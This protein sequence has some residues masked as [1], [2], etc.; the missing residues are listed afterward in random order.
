MHHAPGSEQPNPKPLLINAALTGMVGMPDRIPAIPISAERIARDAWV[1][2]QLGASILHLH[3]RDQDGGPDWH[4]ETYEE[5][6]LA[7]RERCPEAIL[8]V[9][10]SGRTFPELERRAAALAL[11]GDAKPDM[12]SLTLGSLDF[13]TG[14]SVNPPEMVRDLA[15]IMAEA[16]IKPELEVFDSG[17]AN[18][19]TAMLE[20]G[21][22]QAPLYAN[23]ILGAPHTGPATLREL[24]HLTGSLPAGTIWA[25]AGLAA[26]QLEIN[27]ISVFGGG[28][29]RTGLEDNALLHPGVD[30]TNS[31]LVARVAKLAQQAGRPVAGAALARR[32]LGL[33]PSPRRQGHTIRIADLHRDRAAMLRVLEPSNMHHVPSP[34]MDGFEV[35]EW[36]VAESE[37]MIV[38][39]AGFRMLETPAG[40]VGKTTLLAVEPS[41]RSTGIGRA[42]QELRMELMQDAGANRVITN[43]DRPETIAWYERHF[44][45]R[46][47]GSVTKL[48]EFGLPGVDEWTTLEATLPP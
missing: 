22:L 42:L 3:A 36:F 34:E 11:A 23:V 38:G 47:V 17:M 8:C 9:S 21:E 18:V 41:I 6:L 4:P 31:A 7:V 48:H 44:G 46:R 27:S 35:G 1:C 40:P 25:G 10:T 28:H 2:H 37:G 24:A 29:V 45:Y 33:P 15:R 13:A 20:R 12:A 32:I 43:A 39:V 16:E 30:A 14:P 19:A 26:A 5:I